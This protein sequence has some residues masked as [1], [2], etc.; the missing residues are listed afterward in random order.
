MI[1]N[2]LALSVVGLLV[3]TMAGTVGGSI[4]MSVK[5]DGVTGQ[6]VRTNALDE[7]ESDLHLA[8]LDQQS[9]ALRSAF[10]P[11]G[12]T[13]AGFNRSVEREFDG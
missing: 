12:S 9:L 10:T 13:L 2:R 6:A 7:I 4:L 5:F 3:L 8:L 1:R 11:D